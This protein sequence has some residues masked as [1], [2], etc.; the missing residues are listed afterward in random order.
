[1]GFLKGGDGG[2]P[3]SAIGWEPELEGPAPVGQEIGVGACGGGGAVGQHSIGELQGGAGG[4]F[5]G[6]VQGGPEVAGGF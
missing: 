4:D 3:L 1:L 2:V 5:D 6:V